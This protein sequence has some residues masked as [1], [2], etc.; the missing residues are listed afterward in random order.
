MKKAL[1]VLLVTVLFA[2]SAWAE[3]TDMV[4][5][6]EQYREHYSVAAISQ[7]QEAQAPLT[8]TQ[9]EKDIFM[10]GFA[11]GYDYCKMRSAG[12]QEMQYVLNIKSMK[13]HTPECSGGKSIKDENRQVVTCPREDLI[14]QG[15]EPCKSC[16]P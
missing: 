10:L 16:N 9:R 7:A 6:F 4:S 5:L 2:S 8:L 3:V 1:S 15:Y 12:N 14:Q 13:F 11:A